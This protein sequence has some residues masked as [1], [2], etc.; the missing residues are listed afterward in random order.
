MFDLYRSKVEYKKINILVL[1]FLV[2]VFPTIVFANNAMMTWVSEM[3]DGIS[4]INVQRMENGEW[5]EKE[6]VYSSKELNYSPTIGSSQ[7]GNVMIVWTSKSTARSIARSILFRN[8][9]WQSNVIIANQGG[10]VTTPALVFD[11]NNNANVVVVSDHN[12]LDDVYYTKWNEGKNQWTELE[13]VN[14][15]NET[16]DIFPNIVLDCYG[17]VQVQWQSFSLEAKGYTQLSRTYRSTESVPDQINCLSNKNRRPLT[18]SDI[19]MPENW[20]GAVGAAV[21]H[22][23]DNDLVRQQKLP[24]HMSNPN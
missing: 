18:Y 17:D 22:F 4:Q 13:L 21:I 2:S 24:Q 20:Q 10:Q 15:K 9:Q 1:L 19:T 11:H 16:P 6:I 14:D 5:Q 3:G 12:G 8:G 23:P 7:N